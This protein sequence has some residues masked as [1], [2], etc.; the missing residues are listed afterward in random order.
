[1]D[2]PKLAIRNATKPYGGKDGGLLALDHI[3]PDILEG[4]FVSLVGPCGY[5]RTTLLWSI[6]GL[7]ALTGGTDQSTDDVPVV[8]MAEIEE[9]STR[10]TTAEGC[11][12]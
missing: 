7:H 5:S 9:L 12:A 8:R 6:A 2:R 1:M 10:L 4:E 3:G 11:G